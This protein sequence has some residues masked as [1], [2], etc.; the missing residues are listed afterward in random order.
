MAAA[1]V[2]AIGKSLGLIGEDLLG[3]E[4]F[5]DGFVKSCVHQDP[6]N[7]WSIKSHKQW[8]LSRCTS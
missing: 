8:M 2:I 4:D 3:G 7:W 6:I 5:F 1:I